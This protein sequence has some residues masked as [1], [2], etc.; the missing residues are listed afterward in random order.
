MKIVT[1][2]FI[3]FFLYGILPA[4]DHP[5]EDYVQ[6]GLEN[7]LVLK[8]NNLT[9]KQAEYSL[10]IARGMFLPKATLDG[11]YSLAEGGRVIDFPVGDLLNPVY[12]TLNQML[13]QQGQQAGFPIVENEQIN[14]LRP[15]EYDASVSIVQPL[16]SRSLQLNKKIA[17]V[18]LSMSVTEL[19]R[20]KRELVFRI[21][22]AYYNYLKTIQLT[23]LINRT[24]ELVSENYRITQKLLE[25]GKV[26][27]DAV[28]RAKSELSR[29]S[30]MES[31][32]IKN[33]NSAKNY[34]NFLINRNLDADI[35]IEQIH[36]VP[37]EVDSSGLTA[38]ALKYREELSLIEAQSHM[39]EHIA[40]LS[41]AEMLPQIA[42]VMNAGLQGEN[43]DSFD[44]SEYFMGSVVLSWTLFKGNTNRNKRQQA[45]IEK[46]KSEIQYQEVSNQITLEVRRD[47]LNLQEQVNNL[48]FAVNRN[49]EVSEVYRIISKRYAQGETAM[50]E[51]LD[52]RNNMVES[53]SE[54]IN[55]R[56]NLFICIARLEKSSGARLN[57]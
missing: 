50:I 18:Q 8:Q 28:L 30:V 33:R 44:N 21:K 11:R 40:G 24:K 5:L 39:Y 55:T 3:V 43:F 38:N 41:S 56:Y 34:F 15:Q 26:A 14:F 54:L 20:F 29:V 23:E 35:Q 25:N 53:E 2:I 9:L 31:E 36:Y 10:M 4:Q 6:S 45:L 22:E 42:V 48:E 32:L 13:E 12:T 19:E 37:I 16:Y 51:L 7:N 27:N 46:H 17:K 49:N 47:Y 1:S 52:A 57:L